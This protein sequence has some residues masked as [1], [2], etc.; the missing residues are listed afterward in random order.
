MQDRSA[1]GFRYVQMVLHSTSCTKV[2]YFA[3]STVSKADVDVQCNSNKSDFVSKR[4]EPKAEMSRLL[5]VLL[6]IY[7]FIE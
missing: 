5:N 6:M 3:K 2:Q 4:A 1:S 7:D